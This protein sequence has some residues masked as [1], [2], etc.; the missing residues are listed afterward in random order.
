MHNVQDTN[1][2]TN[3]TYGPRSNPQLLF[4]SFVRS[5]GTRSLSIHCIR[6]NNTALYA[7]HAYRTKFK[8]HARTQ[9]HTHLMK[10]DNKSK[11][12]K[13]RKHTSTETKIARK[14]NQNSMDTF[15]I[16]SNFW[17]FKIHYTVDCTMTCPPSTLYIVHTCH[18]HAYIH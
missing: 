7:G 8:F 17:K 14:S 10:L 11:I 15:V 2:H 16:E 5:F 3:C 12:N 6:F 13:K 4:D 18:C 1:T 9:T